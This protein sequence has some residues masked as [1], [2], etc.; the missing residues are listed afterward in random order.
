LQSATTHGKPSAVSQGLALTDEE[1]RALGARLDLLAA[2][3]R[4]A[5]LDDA[6]ARFVLE[7]IAGLVADAA[8]RG[9]AVA[10][11]ARGRRERRGHDRHGRGAARRDAP[12]HHARR[13]LATP[14]RAPRRVR[15][16]VRRAP[17]RRGHGEPRV[18]TD[19][20]Q[21]SMF[22]VLLAA[23]SGS[24]DVGR[25]L[26]SVGAQMVGSSVADV[27]PT[28]LGG[29][30][31]LAPLVAASLSL[32]SSDALAI[33]LSVHAE[34]AVWIALGFAVLALVRPASE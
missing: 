3:R 25:T 7:P 2:L 5:P 32:T 29:T 28:H 31:A 34:Q 23:L 14:G 8:A 21:V 33:P 16:R 4:G 22:A 17:A 10:A 1:G 6:D 26:T 9:R 13:A 19:P 15:A 11:L 24:A 12:R 30:E 27:L 18:G 20:R